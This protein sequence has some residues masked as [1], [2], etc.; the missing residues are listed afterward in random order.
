MV[1]WPKEGRVGQVGA[2]RGSTGFSTW[3]MSLPDTMQGIFQVM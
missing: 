3:L 2:R 1:L